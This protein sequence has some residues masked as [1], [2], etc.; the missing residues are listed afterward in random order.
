MYI[1]PLDLFPIKH[2]YIDV[3]G[4]HYEYISYQHFHIYTYIYMR[5]Y[6]AVNDTQR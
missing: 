1:S 3:Y 2:A 6:I 4:D 5:T